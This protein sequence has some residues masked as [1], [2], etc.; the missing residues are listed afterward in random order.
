[1]VV[2]QRRETGKQKRANIDE[3]IMVELGFSPSLHTRSSIVVSSLVRF[4]GLNI[5]EVSK[6]VFTTLRF[7]LAQKLLSR[8]IWLLQ[9]WSFL[10]DH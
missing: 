10:D 5:V 1:M 9:F 2:V 7:I 8:R 6:T 4:Y 3:T